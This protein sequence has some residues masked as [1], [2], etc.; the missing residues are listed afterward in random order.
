MQETIAFIGGG[1]MATSLIGGL[2]AAGHPAEQIIVVDPAAERRQTLQ[3]EYAVRVL[4]TCSPEAVAADVWVLAVKPQ[5]MR[6]VVMQLPA[7]QA[8]IVSV[9]AGISVDSLAAWM[10]GD[11]AIVRCMPNT[12]ALV[13]AGAAALFAAAN[14]SEQ[15]R[16]SAQAIMQSAG[17]TVWVESEAEI[18]AV[19]ATSGSGPAYF[20]AFMEAM[21]SN[22][23]AR[24]AQL[25]LELAQAEPREHQQT[26]R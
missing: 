6:Q 23:Q 19:T 17:L 8:L 12:P 11:S 24:S 25:A 3:D 16:A 10:Q 2:I 26:E 14:V 20:F 13:G 21:Q 1:N 7:T 15:Q 9:A 4:P 5:V 18:D 22:A